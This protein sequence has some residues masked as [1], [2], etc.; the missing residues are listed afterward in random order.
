MTT[1]QTLCGHVALITGANKNGIGR[2]IA[3]RLAAH[4]ARIV[5]HGSGRASAGL[6]E[7][8]ELIMRAG[9]SAACVQTD[10]KDGEARA[11]LVERASEAYGPVD[12]LINNAGGVGAYA[13]PSKIDLPARHATF[14]LNFQAPVDLIQ[15][16]LPAMRAQSWGRIINITSD[17]VNPPSF[18]IV[19]SPKFIHALAIY[20]AA[21]SALDRYTIGLAAELHGSGITAN[22]TKPYAV[23]W[24]ES[25]DQLTRKM[26]DARPDL[27]EGLD[28]LAEA[29][30]LL[31]TKNMTGVVLDS[32]KILQ[33]LRAPLHALNGETVTGDAA[34]LISRDAIFGSPQ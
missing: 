6:E 15:Q 22:A 26:F 21:K 19:G 5:L 12:I 28:I 18:P 14:E 17:S 10:L 24:S 29:V 13:P 31:V 23:A 9:G 1:E 25:A 8:R 33:M 20:G 34:T 2:A 7:T 11:T 16:A 30:F 32:R 3:R 27:I 4:G